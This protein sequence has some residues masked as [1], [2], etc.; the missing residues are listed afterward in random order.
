[1]RLLRV[2]RVKPFFD[3]DYQV[4]V[5][6]STARHAKVLGYRDLRSYDDCVEY[7]QVRVKW[8]R[9]DVPDE[10]TAPC[11]LDS[12]NLWNCAAWSFGEQ[13]GDLNCPNYE[14]KRAEAEDVE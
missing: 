6:H 2:Y 10:L 7:D 1:M 11:V 8:L 5:I 3:A 9:L 12:C 14:S 13:C 4:L